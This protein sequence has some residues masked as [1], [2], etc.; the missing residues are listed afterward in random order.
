MSAMAGAPVLLKQ[1]Y[2]QTKKMLGW[3]TRYYRLLQD[4]LFEFPSHDSKTPTDEFSLCDGTIEDASWELKLA[5]ALRVTTE[6]GKVF[7]F[8]CTDSKEHRQ[9]FDAIYY[10]TTLTRLAE[11]ASPLTGSWLFYMDKG[12]FQK[13]WF[14]IK[15]SFLLCYE[16][17]EDMTMVNDGKLTKRKFVLPLNGAVLAYYKSH[18]PYSFCIQ[19]W[20]HGELRSEFVLAAQSEAVMHVWMEVLYTSMGNKIEYA[21]ERD[22]SNLPAVSVLALTLLAVTL[23]K[24]PCRSH[25]D[26]IRGKPLPSK[27]KAETKG[28][29]PSICLNTLLRRATDEDVLNAEWTEEKVRQQKDGRNIPK[30]DENSAPT[31]G[32]NTKHDFPMPKTEETPD[33]PAN[34]EGSFPETQPSMPFF[35]GNSSDW[36]PFGSQPLRESGG[37]PGNDSWNPLQSLW[38]QF[39][40]NWSNLNA[41]VTGLRD[42]AGV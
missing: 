34:D 28:S 21:D 31:N 19:M 15:D 3:N 26:M 24:V 37:T 5:N 4:C 10:S 22:G 36:N 29:D 7:V 32:A 40:G 35:G 8:V 25:P 17:R 20:V 1:G 16:K 14:V 41:G 27:P 13:H 33:V 23:A 18:M 6:S 30:A 38:S 39:G 11:Y 9:W 2:M 12:K 42:S